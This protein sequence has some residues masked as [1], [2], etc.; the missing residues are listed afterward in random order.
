MLLTGAIAR[1]MPT[2]TICESPCP[3]EVALPEELRADKALS[4]IILFGLDFL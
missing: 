2:L 3:T 1:T 4:D